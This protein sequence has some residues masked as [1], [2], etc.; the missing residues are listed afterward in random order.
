M[1][2]K[3]G[4]RSWMPG[5]YRHDTVTADFKRPAQTSPAPRRSRRPLGHE[6]RRNP[7]HLAGNHLG[8]REVR[9]AKHRDEEL[10]EHLLAIARIPS[11]TPAHPR[12]LRSISHQLCAAAA[13]SRS[14][15]E[16]LPIVVAESRCTEDRRVLFEVLEVQELERHAWTP[17]LCV[18][19]HRVGACRSRSAAARGRTIVPRVCVAQPFG[20]FPV[21]PAFSAREHVFDT[22]PTLTPSARA[23]SL[24]DSSCCRRSRKISRIFLIGSRSVGILGLPGRPLVA[25]PVRPR[26]PR[27]PPCSRWPDFSVHDARN[28]RSRGRSR[29][30]RCSDLSVHDASIPLFTIGRDPHCETSST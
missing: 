14:S 1:L 6:R 28:G 30:S 3:L 15:S 26:H 19:M 17:Q 9:R 23:A 27:S 22:T 12:S 11:T 16:P 18:Q 21:H 20:D 4:V 25:E 24:T 5:S 8:I 7:D 10:H 2:R 29:C 13:S